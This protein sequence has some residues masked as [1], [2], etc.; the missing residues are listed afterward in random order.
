MQGKDISNIGDHFYTQEYVNGFNTPPSNTVQYL[1]W[2]QV[3]LRQFIDSA[4]KAGKHGPPARR[5]TSKRW[6]RN[7]LSNDMHA[8]TVDYSIIINLLW[9]PFELRWQIRR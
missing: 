4:G 2:S 9:W 7:A 8:Q 3:I 5:R 6:F 1:K